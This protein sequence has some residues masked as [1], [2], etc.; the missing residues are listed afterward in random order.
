MTNDQASLCMHIQLFP[1]RPEPWTIMFASTHCRNPLHDENETHERM[2][3][4]ALTLVDVGFNMKVSAAVFF[5]KCS[6]QRISDPEKRTS[7]AFL[8]IGSLRISLVDYVCSNPLH[9]ERET[10]E[11]M[12]LYALPPHQPTSHQH[13]KKPPP[14]CAW[15]ESIMFA[16]I[17]YMMRMKRT[18]F[19]SLVDY[20]SAQQSIAWWEWNAR[21]HDLIHWHG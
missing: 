2:F 9:D 18:H 1:A 15:C 3:L 13:W 11:H 4:Y 12:F 8:N 16:A 5:S 6:F 20:M 21:T 14:T 19:V 7:Y 10:H 17:H